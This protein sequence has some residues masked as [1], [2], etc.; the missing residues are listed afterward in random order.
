MNVE[1]S[2]ECVGKEVSITVTEH[3][4]EPLKGAEVTAYFYSMG[5]WKTIMLEPTDKDGKTSF[6]PDDAGEYRVTAVKNGYCTE[7]NYRRLKAAVST[8][9]SKPAS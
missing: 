3:S 1:K 7:M 2:G 4:D 5:V 8:K 9:S 6:T